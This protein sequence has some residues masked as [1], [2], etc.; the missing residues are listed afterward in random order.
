MKKFLRSPAARRTAWMTLVAL[1]TGFVAPFGVSRADAQVGAR[2]AYIV[3]FSAGAGVQGTE[4]PQRITSALRAAVMKY[5]DQAGQPMD[6]I[7]LSLR[8]PVIKQGLEDGVITE[9]VVDNPP[10]DLDSALQFARAIG[11]TTVVV[12]T[13]ESYTEAEDRSQATADVT[14]LEYYV[15]AS[16]ELQPSITRTVSKATTVTATEERDKALLKTAI[17]EKIALLVASSLLDAPQIAPVEKTEPTPEVKSKGK[18]TNPLWIVFG[19]LA[20]VAGIFLIASI[21]GGGSNGGAGNLAVGNVR[22]TSVNDAVQVDWDPIAGAIGY[23]IYRRQVRT[24]TIRSRGRQSTAGFE[25]LL[26]PETNTSPT[27]LGNNRT[28]FTDATATNGVIYEYAVTGVGANNEEGPIQ[29]TGSTGAQAGANIGAAPSL[30]ATAGNGFVNLS[31][32]APSGFVDGYTIFRRA[33]ENGAVLNPDTGVNSPNQ[34]VQVTAG[35]QY[36][37]STVQNG[38][39]YTYIVQPF[40]AVNVNGQLVGTD[41]NPI[42]V[43]PAAGVAPSAPLNASATV[44]NDGRV[45]ISWQANPETN[46]RSY[47]IFRKRTRSRSLRPSAS[48][49]APWLR[50]DAAGNRSLAVRD[51][52]RSRQDTTNDFPTGYSLVGTSDSN[53]TSF[54]DGPLPDGDYKY[55]VR[56]VNSAG[57][58]GNASVTNEVTVNAALPAPA[59]VRAVGFDGQV[60]VSWQEVFGDVTAYNVYRSQQ[61]ITAAMTGPATAPGIARVG[62]VGAG[63]LAFDDLNLNNNLVFYY[64]VTAVD[65]QGAESDFGKGT[66]PDTGVIG[67]PHAAPAAMAFTVGAQNLSGNGQSTTSVSA[68]LTDATGGPTGGVEVIL[69]TEAGMFI[70]LPSTA[71]TIDSNGRQV[72][73]LTDLQGQVT[74][75][76]RSSVVITP[77]EQLSVNLQ[78]RAAELPDADELQSQ[79][80]SFLASRPVVVV[81]SPTQNQ[82]TADRATTTDVTAQVRDALGQPVPDGLFSVDFLL[83]ATNGSIRRSG[84][85]Q[86]NPFTD[87]VTTV[88]V[89]VLSGQAVAV[90]RAGND[91]STQGNPPPNIV[92][93]IGTVVGTQQGEPTVQ[94]QTIITLV[95]G[96]AARVDFGQSSLTMTTGQTQTLNVIAR[97]AQGNPVRTGVTVNFAVQPTDAPITVP[98]SGTTDTNG[99]IM[100][101]ITAGQNTGG[102]VII[103]TIPGT[104]VQ[105]QLA[106]TVQ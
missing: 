27:V 65:G 63:T 97:D 33:E 17:S 2:T 70:N 48:G 56:A 69:S 78:A 105:S 81:L 6:L 100:L 74:L 39:R 59:S 92:P 28:S 18:G 103:A 101:Q 21:G 93:I 23:N 104:Q 38:L 3:P 89:P 8:N 53:I 35:T 98:P 67:I 96:V 83:N 40:T 45:T 62:S 42:T 77:G 37:D 43:T 50:G 57:Q 9:D 68:T 88:N 36:T 102:G 64:A 5:K 24:Q 85:V 47:E 44:L 72:R 86:S 76:L 82:L 25:L 15:P 54:T 20:A 51:S 14:V 1:V 32:T 58:R 46:V 91:S 7:G 80:I 29:N 30:T 60:R 41:S 19:V 49:S 73:G 106:V 99:T 31:W 61:P 52:R 95:P 66:T 22:A 16:V 10:G 12:G 75:D 87:G 34:L 55:A 4:I 71:T 11:L 90:Y 26:S 13:V 84:S 79:T 94:S